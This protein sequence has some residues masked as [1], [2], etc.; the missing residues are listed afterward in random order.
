MSICRWIKT[1][2]DLDK[3]YLLVKVD[4]KGLIAQELRRIRVLTV[5]ALLPLCHLRFLCD[6]D[7]VNLVNFSKRLLEDIWSFGLFAST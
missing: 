1:K 3:L 5:P 6:P 4:R 2:S 7:L